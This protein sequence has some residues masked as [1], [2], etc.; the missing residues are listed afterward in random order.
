MN[1]G[2]IKQER[3]WNRVDKTCKSGC[4]EW[5]AGLSSSGYGRFRVGSKTENAHRVSWALAN[6][7][8]PTQF[9]L[10]SC[11]NRKCVNPDHLREGTQK[12]NMDDKIARGRQPCCERNGMAK[13]TYEIAQTIRERYRAGGITQR[14]LAKEYG[15]GQ[16]TIWS[17]V[18]NESYK[19]I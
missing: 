5:R 18:C 17:I 14:D 2:D 10:H 7:R 1:L 9:V 12:E 19:S 8:S 15:V 11:D 13:L 4:W 3:Y 16:P 6:G